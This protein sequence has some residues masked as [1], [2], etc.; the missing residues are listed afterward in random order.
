VGTQYCPNIF[1][2]LQTL[3]Y[4]PDQRIAWEHL[5][6]IYPGLDPEQAK[7]RCELAYECL[8]RVAMA[9]KNAM[10]VVGTGGFGINAVV[11]Q[12]IV[13]AFTDSRGIFYPYNIGM[14]AVRADALLLCNDAARISDR[15]MHDPDIAQWP[16]ASIRK[17]DHDGRMASVLRLAARQIVVP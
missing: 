9:E 14:R 16:S 2:R 10:G 12:M 5:K 11:C 13:S 7:P 3:F 15:I 1:C 8:V 6:L 17:F 4:L